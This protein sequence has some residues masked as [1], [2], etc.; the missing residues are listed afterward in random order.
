MR[1]STLTMEFVLVVTLLNKKS[2]KFTSCDVDDLKQ[3]K[4]KMIFSFKNSKFVTNFLGE[5]QQ[6]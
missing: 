3:L 6:K 4:R 2:K 1:F 5:Q